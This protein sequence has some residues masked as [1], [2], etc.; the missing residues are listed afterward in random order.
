MMLALLAT[1]LSPAGP[2]D[3]AVELWDG[4]VLPVEVGDTPKFTVIVRDP[5]VVW[6]ALSRPNTAT[7]G[8]AYV[9]GDLEIRGDLARVLEVADRVV[10]G[11]PS[12]LRRLVHA[13]SVR[14]VLRRAAARVVH[15]RDDRERVR[16]AV[17]FHYD[18]PDAFFASWLDSRRVYSCAY[19]ESPTDSLDRA[20][21][22]KLEHVCNKLMLAP[23]HQFLDV[24]CG[25]GAL[26][27]HAARRGAIA[28]GITLSAK[29][30]E[31]TERLVARA[32]LSAKRCRVLCVDYRDL[33]RSGV[34]YDRIASVGMIEHVPRGT[35]PAY[36]DT[37]FGMLRPGG[38]LLNHGITST[39]TRPLRGGNVFLRRHVFPEHEIVPVTTSLAFAERSGF[40]VRDVE[41]LREHYAR[42]LRLWFERLH[43]NEAEASA[44]VGPATFRAFAVY[45]A[46]MAYHFERGNLQIHQA[47]LA[48]PANGDA[49]MPLTRAH[50]YRGRGAQPSWGFPRTTT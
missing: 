27:V 21:E 15:D 37:L 47:L 41:S 13:W 46:G 40:E 17:R 8:E 26:L 11:D 25:W 42:T 20:Q 32:G 24:G 1:L 29:Q 28:T 6:R 18:L 36:F 31:H 30:A 39:P 34:R 7:L 45:L 14:P 5:R 16:R 38:L 35:Q 4:R 22:Q 10:N 48:K 2:R 12:V 50:L 44:L 49:G 43:A 19:F 33:A 23:D 3:F 9:R